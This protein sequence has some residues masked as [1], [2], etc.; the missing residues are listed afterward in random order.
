M[1]PLAGYQLS[2]QG[3]LIAD[4]RHSLYFLHEAWDPRQYDESINLGGEP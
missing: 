4:I 3:M 2:A 1:W